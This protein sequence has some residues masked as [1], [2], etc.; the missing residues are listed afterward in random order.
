MLHVHNDIMRQDGR[1]ISG[2]MSRED[3]DGTVVI[4]PVTTKGSAYEVADTYL[5]ALRA[6]AEPGWQYPM[7]YA[8]WVA[9]RLNAEPTVT[10]IATPDRYVVITTK[11]LLFENR[12]NQVI[13]TS[14]TAAILLAFVSAFVLSAF[15]TRPRHRF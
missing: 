7:Q 11:H 14:T 10:S 5:P 15:D 12:R 2:S 13:T 4:R 9:D 1:L 3:T 8:D 6:L